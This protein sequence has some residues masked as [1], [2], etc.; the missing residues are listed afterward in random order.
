MHVNPSI[1]GILIAASANKTASFNPLLDVTHT[2]ASWY[3]ADKETEYIN[4]DTASVWTD[5]G[6][7]NRKLGS[8]GAVTGPYYK[9]NVINFLPAFEFLPIMYL[10]ASSIHTNNFFRNENQTVFLVFKETDISLYWWEKALMACDEGG[11]NANK[12]IWSVNASGQ[13]IWECHNKYYDCDN[14]F[15]SSP[16]IV[17]NNTWT[18]IEFTRNSADGYINCYVNGTIKIVNQLSYCYPGAINA[19]FSVGWGEGSTANTFTGHIAELL[20]YKDFLSTFDRERVEGYLA[21]KY[22][23]QTNLPGNHPYS[24]LPPSSS[25]IL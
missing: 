14:E 6:M 1:I 15:R 9:T 2:D 16:S 5:F 10:T 12:W 17:R 22:G 18:I 3:A 4:N 11:G 19:P 24:S 25:R 13:I 23:L 8:A 21:W 7:A 20:F